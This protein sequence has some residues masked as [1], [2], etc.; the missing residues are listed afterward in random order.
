M[1]T[2]EGSAM[3]TQTVELFTEAGVARP[4]LRG[5]S[6]NDGFAGAMGELLCAIEEDREPL[7][8]ARDNLLSLKLCQAALHS[9]RAGVPAAV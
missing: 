3:A 1:M 6:F 2:A 5:A 8:S 9:V 4:P 7:N